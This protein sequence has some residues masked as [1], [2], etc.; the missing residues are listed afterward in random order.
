MPIQAESRSGA[1]KA[2]QSVGY[3]QLPKGWYDGTIAEAKVAQ[4][5]TGKYQGKNYINAQLKVVKT[6][7]VGAGRTFFVKVPLFSNWQPSAKYPDGFPTL[8]ASFFSAL[9][10]SDSDIDA[11]RIPFEVSDLGGKPIGFYL[12]EE[13]AD[14]YHVEDWNDVSRVRKPTTGTPSAVREEAG[15][16]WGTASEPT[17]AASGDV[18]GTSSPSLQAAADSASGF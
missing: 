10:V 11:G 17:P 6:A 7:K 2:A 4:F 5:K 15:D 18:W 9:G 12:T 3:A 16:V 1:T 13:E 8:Y 14:D